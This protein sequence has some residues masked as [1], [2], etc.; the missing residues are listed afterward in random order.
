MCTQSTQRRP[1]VRTA[2][3]AHIT[4]YGMWNYSICGCSSVVQSKGWIAPRTLLSSLAQCQCAPCLLKRGRAILDGL[5]TSFVYLSPTIVSRL[6]TRVRCQ[7]APGG[8][9]QF[10]PEEGTTLWKNKVIQSWMGYYGFRFFRIKFEVT[11]SV[12]KD[13]NQ[14][15][16]WMRTRALW[17]E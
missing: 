13:P 11:Q 16:W 7:H 9:L 12:V 8:E 10:L 3:E 5:M 4:H 14:S 15:W 2:W 1:F 6:T 17:K